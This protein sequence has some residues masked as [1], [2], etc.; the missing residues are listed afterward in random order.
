MPG[1]PA[2]CRTL[3]TAQVSDNEAH[4]EGAM[5]VR[6]IALTLAALAATGAAA[7]AS[8]GAIV[9]TVPMRSDVSD[10]G[11]ARPLTPVSL[12]LTL[13]YRHE[14]E[15][16]ALVEAQSDP[17]SPLYRHYLTNAQFNAYFAPTAQDYARVVSALQRAGFHAGVYDNRTL[18]DADAPA[19]AVEHYFGTEI[20]AAFQAGR[21]L[22]YMNA[23]PA[24]LPAELSAIVDTVVGF[25]DVTVGRFLIERGPRPAVIE[26]DNVGGKLHGPDGGFGPIALANGFDFPVQHGFD[27]TGHAVANVA[28][29]IKD[30]DLAAFLTFFGITRTGTTAR[31]IIQ[32]TGGTNPSDP[33]VAEAT[34]DTETIGSLAPGANLHLYILENPVDKPGEDAYNKIVS[35]NA[36]DL[37]NSSFGVCESD[38]A[39]GTAAA[40]IVKQGAAKGITFS[41]SSGDGGGSNC[42]RTGKSGLLPASLPQVVSVGGTSL[43]V[44]KTGHYVGETAWSGSGGYVSKNYAIPKYQVGVKGLASTTKRNVPDVAFP[45]DPG[46][47]FS[48]YIGGAF[49]GPIG[50][51]SWSSPTYCAL[52]AEINQKD[53]K[54]AGY[55]NPRI[56]AAFA[57]HGYNVF[58]DVTTGGNGVFKAGPG[59]DDVTGIGSIQGFAFAA[60]E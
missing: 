33:A 13:R 28:G 23:R 55:V 22:H 52:Q 29:N 60:V 3:G 26:P 53:G 12:A 59:Y 1:G 15:L 54:R 32:G 44:N 31:T 27:G 2:W 8:S 5:I 9:A 38:R 4:D 46:T 35:D 11:R 49:Q 21:G 57:A 30:S 39:Y 19:A 10:L 17:A 16:D 6:S 50:G 14:N 42:S 36:V 48:F 45:G 34:L 43:S 41:A 20:H 7:R 18:V 25:D 40:K 24:V 58:H 51:T 47:G 56:Y 37:V